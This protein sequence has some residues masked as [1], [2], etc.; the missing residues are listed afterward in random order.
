M[1]KLSDIEVVLSGELGRGDALNPPRIGHQQA[2]RKLP[3]VAQEKG[4][5]ALNL[6]LPFFCRGQVR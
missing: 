5:L 6:K 4:H 3:C 1:G 2:F